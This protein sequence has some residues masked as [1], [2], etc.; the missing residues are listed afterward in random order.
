M[1]S[2]KEDIK[3][4]YNNVLRQIEGNEPD[5]DEI[6][7]II[8]KNLAKDSRV[9]LIELA[10]LTKTETNV[11]KYRINKLRKQNILGNYVL[12]INF[13]K[14]GLQQFQIDFTLKKHS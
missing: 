8:I 6:D 3:I 7:I 11:V 9:N 12:D 1:T 5:I 2:I 14:F 4:I 13:E 10:K